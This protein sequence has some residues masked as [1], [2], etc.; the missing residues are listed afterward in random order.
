MPKDPRVHSQTLP[1][2]FETLWS[3]EF[4]EASRLIS[5]DVIKPYFDAQR[6]LEHLYGC[7]S[8]VQAIIKT[9][10]RISV[11]KAFMYDESGDSAMF[12]Q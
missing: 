9:D 3:K 5:V 2:S 6:N 10:C 4:A 11:I 1:A 7:A 12:I 8:I